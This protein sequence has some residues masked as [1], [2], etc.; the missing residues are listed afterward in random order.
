MVVSLG[1]ETWSASRAGFR[2][3]VHSMDPTALPA[4]M[5]GIAL[6]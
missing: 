3:I 6:R 5:G 4:F 2:L 1:R